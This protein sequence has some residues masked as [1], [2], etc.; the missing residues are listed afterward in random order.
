MCNSIFLYKFLSKNIAFFKLNITFILII[1]LLLSPSYQIYIFFQ[2]DD[3]AEI[4]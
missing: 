1:C 3:F 4:I 2:N